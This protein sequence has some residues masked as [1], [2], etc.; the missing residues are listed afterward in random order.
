[1]KTITN[2]FC[3]RDEHFVIVYDGKF[4]MTVNH[5]LIGA[6]GHPIRTLTWA[7]GLCPGSTLQ[8]TIELCRNRL[9]VDYYMS[10]GMSRADAIAKV[11]NL[12]PAI[13]QII[14]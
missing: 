7:D 4:Y 8:E 2:D 14:Q 9:D 10:Q 12:D 3:Y 1:M 13:L 11:L 5:K 6:D